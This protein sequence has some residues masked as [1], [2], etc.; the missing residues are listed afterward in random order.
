[1]NL[2]KMTLIAF[3]SWAFLGK[4]FHVCAQTRDSLSFIEDAD[5]CRN[6]LVKDWFIFSPS[7]RNDKEEVI[8]VSTTKATMK[9]LQNLGDEADEIWR[10]EKNDE[11]KATG[12][13]RVF[14]H[15][16]RKFIIDI[17]GEISR[18]ENLLSQVV[19]ASYKNATGFLKIVL[20]TG[21][22]GSWKIRLHLWEQKEQKEFP[23]SHKWDFYS[24]IL[25]GI[26]QQQIYDKE[27]PQSSNA[28]TYNVR[29]PKSLMPILPT[30]ELPCP[31]RDHYTLASNP[32]GASFSNLSLGEKTFLVEGESYFMSNSLVHTIDPGMDAISLVFTS[33]TKTEVSEVFTPIYLSGDDYIRNAPSASK[34]ELI[35]ELERAKKILSRL[36][37]HKNYLPEA[38]NLNHCHF[39]PKDSIFENENWRSE[40]NKNCTGSIVKQLSNLSLQEYEVNLGLNQ[41]VW[42]GNQLANTMSPYLF[43]LLNQHMYAAPK[44]FHHLERETICHVSFVNYAPVDSAGVL[45]F[46]ENGTLKSIEA[47]S[48][49]YRPSLSDMIPAKEYLKS[50]GVSIDNLNEVLH[51]D[52]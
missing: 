36:H 5:S 1:M 43:V 10:K 42:I 32:A 33:R 7:L 17:L 13:H 30:G 34:E 51:K 24:K 50:I 28:T 41:T 14:A 52:R 47:Y 31:C 21:G 40:I 25:S 39:G 27:N 20:L 44:D 15:V 49:H 35:E 23:H 6:E 29:F 26:L 38:A 8:Q 3:F 4:S 37:I 12:I 2:P 11:A 46:N 16:D 19:E 9:D 18:D 45:H 22:A 48:G